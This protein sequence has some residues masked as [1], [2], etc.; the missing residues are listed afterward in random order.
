MF[1]RIEYAKNS[2]PYGFV[3]VLWRASCIGYHYHMIITILG[4]PV[5][6]GVT[7]AGVMAVAAM[8]Y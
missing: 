8:V 7:M 4:F 5:L 1:R 3:L 6:Q 2:E